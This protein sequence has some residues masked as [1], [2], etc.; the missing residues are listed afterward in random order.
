MRIR[1]FAFL[2]LFLCGSAVDAFAG[3]DDVAIIIGNRNYV[4]DTPKVEFAER[5]ADAFAKAA[6][7]ILDIRPSNIVLLKDATETAFNRW[8]GLRNGGNGDLA[9]LVRT[10]KSKIY[11]YFSGHGMPVDVSG[12]RAERVLL[13]VDALPQ[14]A[15]T[16]GVRIDVLR[17]AVLKTLASRAPEG[18]AILIFDACFSGLTPSGSLMP[19]TSAVSLSASK[20]QTSRSERLI[21]FSAAAANEVAYWDTE[22]RHGAFT[23][24]LLDGLYGG[25]SDA[26]GRVSAQSLLSFTQRRVSDRLAALSPME[27]KLQSPGLSGDETFTIAS[28]AKPFPQRD[29]ASA[30]EERA[31]CVILPKSSNIERLRKYLSSCRACA[32]RTEVAERLS[33]IERTA[34]DCAAEQ[35]LF[36]QLARQGRSALDEIDALAS[37]GKC[38][39]VR[40]SARKHLAALKTEAQ[41]APAPA[42]TS[43]TPQQGQPPSASPAAVRHA[44][45][46]SFRD[47]SSCPEMVVVPRGSFTIGSPAHEQGRFDDEGGQ[48]PISISS[49]FA[50]G[51]GSVTRAQF[52]EFVQS[53]GYTTGETCT[54]WTGSSWEASDGASWRSPGFSQTAADPVVC[55]NWHDAK[56]YVAWLA[57]TTG[58]RYRLPSEAEREYFTRAGSQSA[59]WWG[60]A[61]RSEQANFSAA[62]RNA[63][64]PASAFSPNPWGLF[65]V[66]GNVW[67]WGEDCFFNSYNGISADGSPRTS[68]SCGARVLRG[69]SW[70]FDARYMRAANRGQRAANTRYNDQGFRVVRSLGY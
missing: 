34:T 66:H 1:L 23:D 35:Q 20:V 24:A 32:C 18:Q 10:P 58:Q 63:T 64:V 39:A 41:P 9:A 62:R 30:A 49:D 55:V 4:G 28:L 19:N 51:R 5:D 12:D 14:R 36:D 31:E 11:I 57:R 8:F 60:N 68:S 50:V 40:E 70:A 16:E 6:R 47:C 15:A 44:V 25:A 22:R 53:T 65:N 69:G 42:R 26:S 61:A 45:G 21:E 56:A 17:Q 48:R 3:P 52:A 43:P 54:I 7:E 2:S 29:D 46:Q 37:D 59:F 38:G 13:P 67:E 33:R 27:R